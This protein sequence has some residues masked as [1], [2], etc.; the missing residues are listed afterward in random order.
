MTEE[1]RLWF[2]ANYKIV[3]PGQVRPGPARIRPGPVDTSSRYYTVKVQ[4]YRGPLDHW[5][6]WDFFCYSFKPLDNFAIWATP[7]SYDWVDWKIIRVVYVIAN[8]KFTL[9]VSWKLPNNLQKYE[10]YT[11]QYR[12]HMYL[13]KVH[14]KG[15]F[16]L[17][18][19]CLV[20]STSKCG[21]LCSFGCECRLVL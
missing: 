16:F 19:S 15:L 1:T 12:H 4:Y 13:Y 6:I 21:H 9:K 17:C 10:M 20:H 7:K 3:R 18:L 2:L 14:L 8:I 5:A 11:V